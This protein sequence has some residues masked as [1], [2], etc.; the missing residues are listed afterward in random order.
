MIY[1]LKGGR[2]MRK[3]AS[4]E[5]VWKVEPIEGADRIPDD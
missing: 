2:M 1:D 4:I 3:L 5:T